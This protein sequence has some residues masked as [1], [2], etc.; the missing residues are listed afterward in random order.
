MKILVD[1]PHP[2]SF[3]HGGLQIQIE[4]TKRGMEAAGLEVE[5]L[6]WWDETQ[7]GNVLLYFSRIPIPLLRMAQTKGLKVVMSDLLSETGS[8]SRLRLRVQKWAARGLEQTLPRDLVTRIGWPA[9][10]LADACLAGTSHE[11]RLMHYLFGAPREKVHVIP[12]G[13]EDAFLNS[14][15]TPRGP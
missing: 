10:R 9:Y 6:R 15:P 5:F 7:R 1:Y 8:R 12:N 13:V 14:P 3:A 2:F 4:Q 11:A